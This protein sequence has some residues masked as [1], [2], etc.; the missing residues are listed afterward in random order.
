MTEKMIGIW[1]DEEMWSD[2]KVI[3]ARERRPIKVIGKELFADYLK[4]HGDGN[5]NFQ[6]DQWTD[7]ADIQATPA[8]MR[9]LDDWQ[10]FIDGLDEARFREM[11]SQAY[12]IKD[13]LD[14]KWEKGFD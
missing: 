2:L 12:A 11:E 7:N 5:P 4:E 13:K 9:T 10:R 14:K 6:L 8:F 3:S 1:V